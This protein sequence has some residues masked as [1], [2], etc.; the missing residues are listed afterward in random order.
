MNYQELLQSPL[1]PPKVFTLAKKAS[2]LSVPVFIQGEQGT[3]KELIAKII[4]YTGD[5]KN[6]KFHKLDCKVLKGNNSFGKELLI[7]FEE[8][9]YGRAP[10]TLYLKEVTAL[11]HQDQSML[12]ELIENG[13]FRERGEKRII[14]NIRYISSSSE[15]VMDKLNQGN[16]LKDLYYKLNTIYIHIPPLRERIEEISNIANFFLKEHSKKLKLRK[17][18]ISDGVLKLFQ[19]YW[20][21]GNL[22]EL[23]FLIL[24]GIIFSENENLNE[25]DLLK[26]AEENSP[27]LSFIKNVHKSG[28]EFFKISNTVERDP[29][30]FSKF[31]IELVHRIKNPL[32]SIKTFTQL[33]KDKFDD[34][35]FRRYFYKIVT[36]DI[37]KVDE[38]M[39]SLLNYVKINTPVEKKDT[40]HSILDD[41]I[42]RYEV[43]FEKKRIKV[44]KRYEK[45]L[46]ETIVHD[47]HLR[48]ILNS[49]IQYALPLIPSNGGIGFITRS[50]NAHKEKDD[51]KEIQKKE[52]A[53]IKIAIIF[54]GYKKQIEPYETLLGI[55]SIEG[56]KAMDFELR[57]VKEIIQQNYGE[58]D[59]FI[60][61]KKN[62][63]YISLKIPIERRRVIS[64]PST[65][66]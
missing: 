46:P 62:H 25:K 42:K 27:F 35:D 28:K 30:N 22:K 40:I 41:V 31:L 57:F 61:H 60:D 20:W 23:E 24:R 10:A 9:D 36:E 53:Y 7:F 65:N 12:L 49:L 4:H 52:K 55:P 37:A 33:L 43:Q 19:S 58:L 56:N 63:T 38:V 54:T 48:Y 51:D 21:P 39:D 34:E 17:I 6:Y 29:Q 3:N 47:E 64:Y 44:L 66:R 8:I 59:F 5:W 26:G 45:N 16:F 50:F 13:I 32:V 1:I 14:R 2:T 11:G 15:N 18:G